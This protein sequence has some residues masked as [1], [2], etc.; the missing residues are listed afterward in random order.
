MLNMLNDPEIDKLIIYALVG[1]CAVLMLA[2]IFLAVKRN[3]YYVDDSGAEVPPPPKKKLF[4]FSKN[5][6]KKEEEAP[7]AVPAAEPEVTM[8]ATAADV[9]VSEDS[10]G[11]EFSLPVFPAEPEESAPV[12]EAIPEEVPQEA[13]EAPAEEPAPAA[14]PA[15]EPAGSEMSEDDV[16]AAVG[17]LLAGVP[18]SDIEEPVTDAAVTRVIER[19]EDM[20]KDEDVFAE[21]RTAEPVITDGPVPTGLEVAVVIGSNVR[22]YSLNQLPVLLGRDATS[23]DLVIAEPAVSRKH[24][25]ILAV[26]SQL[27][28]EDVSEHNGTFLNATKLPSL[29]RAPL[30]AGDRIT[31]GRATIDV[32]KVL[33]GEE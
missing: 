20:P 29:G 4:S 23:C 24:A 1:I 26:G 9:P 8:P 10:F 5:K 14:E 6:K 15:A 30:N 21:T 31:L 22:E 13:P 11:D 33:Y 19:P 17:E 28:I 18:V 3:V 7:A 2:V 27:Y 16:D 32:T 25:R 12:P